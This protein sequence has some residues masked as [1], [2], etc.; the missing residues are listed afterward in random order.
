M[1]DSE[2]VMKNTQMQLKM[3]KKIV[4]DCPQIGLITF[5]QYQTDW[6]NMYGLINGEVQ[7]FRC[8]DLEEKIKWGEYICL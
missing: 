6:V 3:A 2:K 1:I 7:A 4:A 8:K 5:N